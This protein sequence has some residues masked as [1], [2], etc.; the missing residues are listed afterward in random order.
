MYV[1]LPLIT[2]INVTFNVLSSSLVQTHNI[3]GFSLFLLSHGGG[4][5]KKKSSLGSFLVDLSI[6]VCGRFVLT[7]CCAFIF[8]SEGKNLSPRMWITFSTHQWLRCLSASTPA[9]TKCAEERCWSSSSPTSCRPWS[10]ATLTTTG[11]NSKRYSL[12]NDS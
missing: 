8:P 1:G 11:K 4:G 10:L 6:L 5:K 7:F 3:S 9:S 2:L 12:N